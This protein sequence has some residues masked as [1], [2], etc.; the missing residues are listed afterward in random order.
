MK[1]NSSKQNSNSGKP[2]VRSA[3]VRNT[4]TH[5]YEPSSELVYKTSLRERLFEDIEWKSVIPRILLLLVPALIAFLSGYFLKQD[6]ADFFSWWGLLYIY[7]WAAFPLTAYFFHG[8]LSAGYGFSKSFGILLT[9]AAVW[10]LAYTGIF[11]AFSRPMCWMMFFLLAIVSWCTPKT[12]KAAFT[13]LADNS[14]LAHILWEEMLF[15]ILLTALCF[16]KGIFPIING[17]E[18]F[19]NFGFMNSMNRFDGLPAK[20]PWLAGKSI[21]Y[22]Y[23]GQYMFTYLVKM[24]GM[25]TE[26]G[27]NISMC[28]AIAFPFIAAYSLGQLFIDALRQKKDCQ[29]SKHYLPFAGL[30]AACTTMLFGNSHSFFYDEQ[31]FGNKMLFW[32]IWGKLGI[33]VGETGQ[34]FYPNSTRFIGHNP[35]PYI[36]GIKETADWTIHEFPFY[37]YLIGD[38]HAH[39]VSL[40]VVML[41]IAF[42]FV[43]VYRADYPKKALSSMRRFRDL[44]KNLVSEM[45]HIFRPEFFIC[46]FFLGISQMCNYWDFLI[47]FIFCSMGLLV[48]HGRSSTYLISFNSFIVFLFDLAAVLGV[49]LKFG[50]NIF[51]HLCL[52]ILIFMIAYLLS[53]IFPSAF[54]RTGTNMA[55]LFAFSSMIALSFN[56]NFDMISNSIKLVDRHTS[57]FQFMIVWLIHILVPLALILLV[58]FTKRQAFKRNKLP[59][60]PAPL[61]LMRPAT[62]AQLSGSESAFAKEDRSVR[63]VEID[64]SDDPD[65]DDPD[66]AAEAIRNTAEKAQDKD[67]SEELPEVSEKERSESKTFPKLILAIVCLIRFLDYQFARLGDT[68]L[69]RFFRKRSIIDIFMVGMTVV[70]MMMLIA[71]EIIYVPDIYGANNQRANTMFKFTFAGFVILSLVVAYTVFRFMAHVTKEGNLSN[72]GLGVSII[73][74]VLIIF[75]PGHYTLRALDQRSGEIKWSTYQGLNGTDYLS[76]CVPHELTYYDQ[77]R[78]VAGAFIPYEE[79]IDWLNENEHDSVNICESYG[80]SYTEDCLVSAYTGLP[81]IVGWETHERLW[82]FHGWTNPE[83]GEFENDPEQDVFKIYLW[84]RQNDVATLYTSAD[85]FEVARVIHEYDLR[86]IICGSMELD[87]FGMIYYPCI[88]NL[89]GDP[90]FTSSDGSLRIYK[91]HTTEDIE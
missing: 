7:G 52:Q 3:D 75:I 38:L 13:A 58:I 85:V 1:K 34:F 20:D 4:A 62:Y 60:T 87:Q 71:P 17:E 44:S 41:I 31:S 16:C 39:V 40:T 51:V 55:L 80:I 5:L 37:S 49:Y 63:K 25:N 47:Y 50:E 45:S 15:I 91:V 81:T 78:R 65:I 27:Y 21:N 76:T 89:C 84:P 77:S 35:D 72:W 12:R 64:F 56:Y 26:V 42:I 46:A 54:S 29:V 32:K 10:L 83:T 61:D 88:E 24:L 67:I 66:F 73:M 79:A 19:M 86:Y 57:L 68:A 18:K 9:T 82:H 59:V 90:V 33:D 22:Y 23:Y 30:L 48:Y 28:T 53:T 43:A 8:F 36:Q 6:H 2:S 69:C 14:N 11:N 74:L 70:G